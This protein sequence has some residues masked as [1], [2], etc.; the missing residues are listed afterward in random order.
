MS[1]SVD[2]WRARLRALTDTIKPPRP[3][4][5]QSIIG[6]LACAPYMCVCTWTGPNSCQ[7]IIGALACAPGGRLVGSDITSW[8]SVDHWRARLRAVHYLDV[9]EELIRVSVDHWRARLRAV[10]RGFALPVQLAV[11][12][13]HWRARLRARKYGTP[14]IRAWECQSIIGALACAPCLFLYSNP[15]PTSVSRS[16]ARSPARL[17]E[18]LSSDPEGSGVSRSLARSPARLTT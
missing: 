13:D 6:A 10:L 16:L 1:V 7:S 18:K 4:L 17:L 15:A 11:S 9:I 8:V 12:V 2:H 14:F 3:W 5:C